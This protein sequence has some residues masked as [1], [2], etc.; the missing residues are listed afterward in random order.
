VQEEQPGV[1]VPAEGRQNGGDDTLR[2]WRES[3]R[4]WARSVDST[5]GTS[6]QQPLFMARARTQKKKSLKSRRV[7]TK[8]SRRVRKQ[9]KKSRPQKRTF[10]H[11]HEP[12]Y[13]DNGYGFGDY[14]YFRHFMDYD[15]DNF[16]HDY[17]DDVD[18]ANPFM[19]TFHDLMDL[20]F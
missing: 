11:K 16:E 7:T 4:N 9:K 10:F 6:H 2:N 19:E 5:A 8:P 14:D 12:E 17:K 20:F 18:H 3:V 15:D 13:H 1:E